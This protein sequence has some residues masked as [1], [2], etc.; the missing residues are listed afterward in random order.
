[1]EMPIIQAVDRALKILDLFDEHETE[2]KITEISARLGLHKSTVHS[3][4][5]TLQ[6]HRYIEQNLENGKYRLG[7]KLFERGNYVLSSL[8][9][10]AIAKK[11]MLELSK[12]TGHT[13]HLGAM[14]DGN[15][16]VYIEKVEGT[17]GTIVY[18][19]IGR[20]IP[21]HSSGVGK[22]LA[23]FKSDE[24]LRE[25]L[26]GYVYNVHTP[27]T[28]TNEEDFLRE[29]KK[30][31]ERGYAV[32]NEENEPG[33]R[34]I[35]VP[36]RNHLGEVV[37]AMSMSTPISHM[38]K[39]SLDELVTMLKHAGDSISVQLGYGVTALT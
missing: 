20:R 36:I 13:L 16:G 38:E 29:L 26:H 22:V 3:L 6:H 33:V 37:V 1:M 10:R 11:Y 24:E 9:I 5:K 30:V 34:C 32:D 15:E 25:N 2:L 28:I 35:A 23:A 21:L 17:S 14:L 19:R 8:D 39:Y 31:R 7:M 18:S 12:K 27:N 4:L